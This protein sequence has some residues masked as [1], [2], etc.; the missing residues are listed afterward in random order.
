[1]LLA[2][3]PA[4]SATGEDVWPKVSAPLQRMLM[5][6]FPLSSTSSYIAG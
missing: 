1:V 3:A 2:A 6:V 4:V 5:L